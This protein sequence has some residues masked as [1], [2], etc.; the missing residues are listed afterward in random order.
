MPTD[1]TLPGFL[2]GRAA[3]ATPGTDPELWHSADPADQAEARAICTTCPLL[4]ACREYAA[5]R[6]GLGGMW[7]GHT[8][9]Q[10]ARARARG[11]QVPEP[12]RPACGTE[13]A[14]RRH[15]GLGERCA[16]CWAAEA[17]RKRERRE[18]ALEAEHAL[19]A[20]GSARGYRIELQLGLRPCA[21]CAAE[22]RVAARAADAARRARRARGYASA[23]REAQ[24]SPVALTAR[25][26][27]TQVAA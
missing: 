12:R 21:R 13:P 16:R 27:P 6:T 18:A 2:D 10:R 8:L 23:A 11:Q 22:R 20:G 4:V 14:F 15:C 3:C 26:A 9:S 5:A 19:P 17:E 1:L 25:Q 7:G 24:G